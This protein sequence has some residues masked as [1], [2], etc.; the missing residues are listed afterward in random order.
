MELA[1]DTGIGVWE[2][3][4]SGPGTVRLEPGGTWG[5]ALIAWGVR[6]PESAPEVVAYG[7]ASGL[8][9]ATRVELT[10]RPA[11]DPDGDWVPTGTPEEDNCPT[12]RNPL[13]RDE[14]DDGV[15]DA[16]D[17]CPTVEDPDQ[18][19]GDGDGT[20]DACEAAECGD[21]VRQPAE[22][23]DDGNRTP[24]DGCS[25]DCRAEVCGNGAIDPGEGCDDGNRAPGDGC[26]EDCAHEPVRTEVTN[27]TCGAPRAAEPS[28]GRPWLLRF[29]D[30]G[31]SDPGACDLV[32]QE[33]NGTT[34][35][36]GPVVV[37]GRGRE[38]EPLGLAA[39]GAGAFGVLWFERVDG[40]GGGPWRLRASSVPFDGTPPG[41]PEVVAEFATNAARGWG[42]WSGEP[43]AMLFERPAEPA[44]GRWVE[45]AGWPPATGATAS[46]ERFLDVDLAAGA[47][48]PSGGWVAAWFGVGEAA[49][50][51]G[52]VLWIRRFDAERRA[53]DAAELHRETLAA[54]D[55][56]WAVHEPSADVYLVGA[57]D[58]L[59]TQWYRL[60]PTGG[61]PDGPLAG[62][63]L[64]WN[65]QVLAPGDGTLLAAWTRVEGSNCTLRV[66]PLDGYGSP[67]GPERSVILGVGADLASCGA[68]LLPLSDGRVLLVWSYGCSDRGVPVYFLGWWLLA[69]A[70]A[71]P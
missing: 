2:R 52:S 41:T 26:S 42:T 48:R 25:G 35:A 55:R 19:D 47:R 20:G 31:A 24:G 16:C 43:A 3:S 69:S 39:G 44:F 30:A 65:A 10:L 51:L 49:P 7:E 71:L 50:W 64:P 53:A 23:C 17:V 6:G 34:G 13:Q 37:A 1:L 9:G 57:T 68:D 18:R 70:A 60:G 46:Q 29:A 15:G 59:S 66:Q 8:I 22:E 12:T 27:A 11:S 32:L 56:V 5:G 54:V 45:I 21:G 67:S 40:S 38:T 4:L 36:A 63:A 14:D 33:V 62:A 61:E 28:P 58:G